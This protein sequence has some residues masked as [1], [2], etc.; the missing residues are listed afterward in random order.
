MQG[1]GDIPRMGRTEWWLLTGSL[2][3]FGLA[4][5]RFVTG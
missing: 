2:A 3:A 5:V 4:L 1:D